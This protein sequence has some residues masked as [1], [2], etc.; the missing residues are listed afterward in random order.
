MGC[1]VR[2]HPLRTGARASRSE[3]RSANVIEYDR[4]LR[5]IA[6]LPARDDQCEDLLSL[7]ARQVQLAREPATRTP[8]PVVL[9]SP[10][11]TS[12]CARQSRRAPAAC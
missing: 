1:L 7:L 5:A 11:G 3:P 12:S 2:Q 9:G 10:T 4:E 8:E 6:A